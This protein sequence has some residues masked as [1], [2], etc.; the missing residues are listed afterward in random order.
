MTDTHIETILPPEVEAQLARGE[1]L[2]PRC[3]AAEPFTG[4]KGEGIFCRIEKQKLHMK[5]SAIAIACFC[6]HEYGECP[7]WQTAQDEPDV[8]ERQDKARDEKAVER[9]SQRHIETGF[10]TD[11]PEER[12]HAKWMETELKRQETEELPDEQAVRGQS[13][14]LLPPGFELEDGP[15]DDPG[16]TDEGGDDGTD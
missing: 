5:G 3:P 7:T 15:G 9:Q 10:R 1:G 2:V 16:T 14:I 12:E 6:C 8:V 11:T 13:G 4:R